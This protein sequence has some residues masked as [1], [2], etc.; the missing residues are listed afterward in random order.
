MLLF[1][2]RIALTILYI[3]W[4]EQ[5]PLLIRD[6]ETFLA[7]LQMQNYLKDDIISLNESYQIISKYK[8]KEN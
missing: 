1:S 6:E 2:Q 3:K 7:Y 4:L 8:A 5:H